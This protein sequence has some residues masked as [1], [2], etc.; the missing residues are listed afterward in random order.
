MSDVSELFE[1]DIFIWT[2]LLAMWRFG[3]EVWQRE[4]K[5]FNHTVAG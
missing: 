1:N 4:I 2:C 5:T 3:N